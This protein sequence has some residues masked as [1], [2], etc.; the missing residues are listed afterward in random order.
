MCR[1]QKPKD[2]TSCRAQGTKGEPG[3]SGQLA[4]EK[5]IKVVESKKRKPEEREERILA[6]GDSGVTMS[7][8]RM[9]RFDL[10]SYLRAS[11]APKK[12]PELF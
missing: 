3:F 9:R 12:V 8:F 6:M 4:V 1:K 7:R 11:H 10:R 2:I 5:T